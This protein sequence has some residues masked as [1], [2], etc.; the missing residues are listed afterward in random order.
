MNMDS[1]IVESLS[2]W[3]GR[4]RSYFLS[5][6]LMGTPVTTELLEDLDDIIK[7]L[8]IPTDGGLTVNRVHAIDRLGCGLSV[9]SM[10]CDGMDAPNISKVIQTQTGVDIQPAVVQQ[11]VDNYEAT[12]VV[13]RNSMANH[14]IFDT[15]NRMEDLQLML[16]RLLA[17]VETADPTEFARAKTTR[18]EV[19]LAAIGQLRSTVKDARQVVEA[20]HQMN[21]YHELA[22]II[23]EEIRLESPAVAQRILQVLKKKGVV[24]KAVLPSS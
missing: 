17:D 13:R 5:K 8:D 2:A 4:L 15:K 20:L 7:G 18:Y 1:N 23:V 16:E 14:S 3:R 24:V 6:S 10:Y 19:Q 22:R 12:G 9:L 21:T 11:W